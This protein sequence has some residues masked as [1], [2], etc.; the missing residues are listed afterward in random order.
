MTKQ[1]IL[2]VDDEEII[3][4]SLKDELKA[5]FG[6]TYRIEVA[7]GPEDALELFNELLEENLEIPLVIS[8]YVMPK[9]RGDELLKRIHELSPKTLKVMLTGQA[10]I[11]G[12]TNAI[13]YARL[14]RYITKPWQNEDLRLTVSEAMHCYFQDK[15]LAEKNAQLL[16]MN[17]AMARFV[18]HQFLQALNKSTI[19]DV[20]LGD[21]VQ[22]EM[23]VMFADIRDFTALSESMTPEENFKFINSYLSH[24][25]PVIS[26]HG[27]FIDKYIGD[28][29]MALFGA[30]PDEALQAGIAMLQSLKT[31]NHHRVTSGYLPIQIGIG[32]N[33][34]MLLLGMVGGKRR[35]DSTVISDV[36]NVSSRLEGLTKIY[37]VSL[38]ISQQ[39]WGGL[40]NP[41]AYAMRFI[42]HAKVKG[43]SNAIGVFEVFEADEPTMRSLKLSTK[44][45]FEEGVTLYHQGVMIEALECF[46]WVLSENPA[47]TVARLH[48]SRC[49]SAINIT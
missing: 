25:E 46:D 28:E 18:P 13:K 26:E 22:Q 2:C 30:N 41:N 1:V 40:A 23:S 20:Q 15:H 36:V 4:R 10:T 39:S 47:D 29:I 12:V 7:E 19:L 42:D 14:Y 31:Y 16:Q 45:V 3:L 32:I 11:Q 27:G 17:Q 44:T 5:T 34:G 38:I 24:M 37:G 6:S 48:R 9:M 49:R 33:T 8:D 43:K 21:S 35:M